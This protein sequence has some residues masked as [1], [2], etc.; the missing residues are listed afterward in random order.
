M[1][2]EIEQP[3][4]RCP[5]HHWMITEQDASG[6][7]TWRCQRC[8]AEQTHSSEPPR[9]N[10]ERFLRGVAQSR[11]NRQENKGKHEPL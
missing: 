10:A 2:P 1:E 6:L 8:G 9:K 7:Q 11:I 5:P 3:T 4:Q